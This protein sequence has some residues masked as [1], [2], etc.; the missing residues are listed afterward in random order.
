[1]VMSPVVEEVWHCSLM[2]SWPCEGSLPWNNEGWFHG[3]KSTGICDWKFGAGKAR[4]RQ[5]FQSLLMTST[6]VFHL[7]WQCCSTC[8][9]EM[10]VLAAAVWSLVFWQSWEMLEEAGRFRGDVMGVV[11]AFVV[12]VVVVR[13]L[14]VSEEAKK[15]LDRR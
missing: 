12:V 7:I 3:A 14:W 8:Q 15:T 1:M 2:H 13:I 6:P 10:A 4:R 9:S 11:A 5:R